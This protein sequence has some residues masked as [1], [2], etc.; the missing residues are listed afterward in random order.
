MSDNS[1]NE[2]ISL[3]KSRKRK[4][5]GRMREVS[6]KLNLQSH[7]TGDD[8]KCKKKC[9][10]KVSEQARLKIIR[11]FNLLPST[12]AQNEYLCGLITVIPVCRRRPRKPE[13]EAKLKDATYK[14]KVSL[15]FM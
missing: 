11:R 13:C 5:F 8:C 4:S 12:N 1:E 14:F 3:Q 6:K 15:L 2:T 9:F 7:I 10:N